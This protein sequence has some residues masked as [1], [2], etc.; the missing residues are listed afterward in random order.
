MHEICRP[1][2]PFC[3]IR[4]VVDIVLSIDKPLIGSRPLD[5]DPPSHFK[6]RSRGFEEKKGNLIVFLVVC[7]TM[8]KRSLASYQ[9]PCLAYPHKP[10]CETFPAT[11]NY[12]NYPFKFPLSAFISG[13]ASHLCHPYTLFEILV[14]PS[15][16][17]RKPLFSV[18]WFARP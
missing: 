17:M 7:P 8:E 3:H 13:T 14:K 1:L 16:H 10:T 9:A 2:H 12:Q 11:Q 15:Q 4:F 5:L 18:P 6:T